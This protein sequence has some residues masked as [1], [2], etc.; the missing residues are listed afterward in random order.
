MNLDLPARSSVLSRALSGAL[1]RLLSTGFKALARRTL[2][3]LS[4]KVEMEGL[5]APVEVLRD[6]FGVPQIFAQSEA[7]LFFAQGYVH[8][9]D[10]LFQ[11]EMQRHAG[12]GR[13]AELIGSPALEFDRISRVAGLGRIARESSVE[14]LKEV[15]Y[16]VAGVNAFIKSGP[17]PPELRLLLHRPEPWDPV[18]TAVLSVVVSWSLSSGWESKKI[19]SE[20]DKSGAGGPSW[21]SPQLDPG[22]GLASGSNAW[23]AGPDRC[24]SG[25]AMLAGDPHLALTLPC[26]WYENGLYGGRYKVVGASMP[27]TPGIVLG[28]NGKIAWS[29]TA[30]L[31]DVQDL[32]IERFDP[33]DDSLYEYRGEKRK[34]EIRE[35]RI[36][37]RGRRKPFA[38][39]VRETIHGPIITDATTNSISGS[40]DLALCWVNPEPDRLIEAGLK[41]NRAENWPQFLNA[42]EDWGVPGQNF[43]YADS[44]GNT[45]WALAGRIPVRQTSGDVPLPG[46]GGENEWE[47]YRPF[48][49]HPRTLNPPE[50][51]IASANTPPLPEDSPDYIPGSY[52]LPY[53]HAHMSELLSG[54]EEHTRESFR[55]MQGDLYSAPARALAGRIAG[56]TRIP[57]VPVELLN[58]IENW[59]GSLAAESRAGAVVRLTLEALLRRSSAGLEKAAIPGHPL[60]ASTESYYRARMLEIMANLGR[61]PEELLCEAISEALS[62]I[63]KV[64]GPNHRTWSWGALHRV[65][66]Q[67]PLG[68]LRPLRS[69]LSRGPYPAGGDADTLRMMAFRAAGKDESGR[70]VCSPVTTG[71]GYRFIADLAD[72]EGGWSIIAPG[73]SGN[74]A[75]PH[76]DDQIQMWLEM[77]YRPMVFGRKMAELAAKNRLTLCPSYGVS[78]SLSEKRRVNPAQ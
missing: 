32:Y 70:P 48:A 28:R 30:S 18:D 29:V 65:S 53:R 7:D 76:Y 35:E 10:R 16:Y 61:L 20:L 14:S 25:A 49:E 40:A 67:H 64:L 27:G 31:T 13:L 58:E 54:S 69:F 6:R 63:R 15:R 71:P 12:H 33:N 46:W 43:V 47:G 36:V 24:A 39:H 45:G 38:Q 17:V 75:S 74:P 56:L 68:A 62:G 60:T 42:L 77:R 57:G 52:Q 2:P 59:D 22:S 78:G 50:G 72:P 34:A 73:Q 26:L 9:Q 44:D 55:K 51:Y 19:Y 5:E 66:F 21:L 4:G 37:I 1:A 11:M 8:A 3:D 23:T 41:V